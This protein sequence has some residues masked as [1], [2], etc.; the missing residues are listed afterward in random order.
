MNAKVKSLLIIIGC[1]EDCASCSGPNNDQCLSCKSKSK[2]IFKY[3]CVTE[4]P[5]G[6]YHGQGFCGGILLIYE[7]LECHSS[8]VECSNEGMFS[9]TKCD[10]EHYL[11]KSQC[12]ESC[13]EKTYKDE[14]LRLCPSCVLPCLTDRKSV[15]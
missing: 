6:Y 2:F 12:L 14:I 15:G 9:C 8:C 7:L 3:T 4:C 11:Y 13:P 10:S 1:H 5:P